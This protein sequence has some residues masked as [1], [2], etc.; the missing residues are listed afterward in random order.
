VPRL[1]LSH[2]LPK[3]TVGFSL[4]TTNS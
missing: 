1:G 2:A 4:L 3:G